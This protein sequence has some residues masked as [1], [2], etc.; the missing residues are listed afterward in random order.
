MKL[1]W[2]SQLSRAGKDEARRRIL[3]ASAERLATVFPPASRPI[4]FSS[5]KH[6]STTPIP[7]PCHSLRTAVLS[8]AQLTL[9]LGAIAAP[10]QP[11]SRT[12]ANPSR[13]SEEISCWR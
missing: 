3:S 2:W 9:P 7:A 4:H 1:C 13:P 5:P 6:K 11:R 10:A 8:G 12:D